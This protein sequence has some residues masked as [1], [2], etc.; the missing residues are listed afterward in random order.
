MKEL[1]HVTSVFSSI[2]HASEACID[3][4]IAVAFAARTAMATREVSFNPTKFLDHVSTH[5]SNAEYREQLCSIVQLL[6]GTHEDAKVRVTAFGTRLGEDRWGDG[7]SSGVRQ[8]S[9]WA[10][11]AFCKHPDSYKQCI[12]LAIACGGDVDTTAAM[13]GALVGARLGFAGVPKIWRDAIH[14]LDVWK[15]D[16][17]CALVKSVYQLVLEKRIQV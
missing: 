9:L 5:V 15:L 11:Y 4:S 14:D 2:T 1:K 3:G 13:A 17:V 6:S 7:I 10:I 12:A 8:S 16:D